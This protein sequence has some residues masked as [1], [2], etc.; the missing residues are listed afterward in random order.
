MRGEVAHR[1]LASPPVPWSPYNRVHVQRRPERGHLFADL[2]HPVVIEEE[3]LATG[4]RA[5]AS[6][7]S[8]LIVNAV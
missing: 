8:T 6:R 7:R 5:T 3:M 2:R 1:H 4:Q